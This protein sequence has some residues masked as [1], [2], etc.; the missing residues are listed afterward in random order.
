MP[1]CVEASRPQYAKLALYLGIIHSL[2][3]ELAASHL[4]SALTEAISFDPKLRNYPLYK[5][6][7]AEWAARQEQ[8]EAAELAKGLIN[9][10]DALAR[11]HVLSALALSEEYQAVLDMK[12]SEHEL[13]I[14]LRWYLL[15][16]KAECQEQLGYSLEAI[17]SYGLAADLAKG[18][19]RATM[20]QEQ[21][22]LHL[23]LGQATEAVAALEAAEAA[24]KEPSKRS[25]E[26]DEEG[27]GRATWHYLKAQALIQLGL[28]DEALK[29]ILEAERL[30]QQHGDMSYG[31]ALVKGQV[32]THL[33]RQDEALK[34]LEAALALSS[35]I[36]R[37]YALHELAIVLLDL[38][39][40]VDAREHL[41]TLLNEPDFPYQPEVLADL[42]ECDYRLGRLQEAQ[43][44]AEQAL[45]L[46]CDRAPS[47][48]A[49]QCGLG[50]IFS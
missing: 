4:E 30:E 5:A 1:P 8:P 48:G 11:Y 26:E 7:K 20:R 38:D 27:L 31:V 29:E 22:A 33:D 15:S 14:Y 24:Y 44:F 6:L 42:A 21:A 46:G 16:W 37:P 35:E 25:I 9:V 23:Q 49:G 36:D 40:P 18:I 45:S 47:T 50:S 10:P 3:G 17:A 28:P 34:V 19:N 12:L 2:Y 43:A 41:E 39:R 13:P 32:L